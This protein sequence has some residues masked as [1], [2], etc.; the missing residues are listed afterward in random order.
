MKRIEA[1]IA[2]DL[3]QDVEKAL[4]RSGIEGLTLTSVYS[5]RAESADLNAGGENLLFGTPSC[6]LDVLVPDKNL[7]MV[8]NALRPFV[9]VCTPISLCVMDLELTLPISTGQC[10]NAALW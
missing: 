10:D 8:L 3:I 7:S 6:K 5:H 1:V 4:M 2:H 9:D